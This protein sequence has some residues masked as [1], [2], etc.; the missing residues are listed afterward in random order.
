VRNICARRGEHER[1][2]KH[3]HNA[4]SDKNA[5]EAAASAERL[6]SIM[7][8]TEALT[9]YRAA[10]ILNKRGVPSAA[11]GRWSAT[12]VVRVRRRLAR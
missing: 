6:R 3:G 9:A 10:I 1:T 4:Q 2:K 7:T 8:E 5:A 11:G 12:Q